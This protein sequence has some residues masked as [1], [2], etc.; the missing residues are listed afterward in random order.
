MPFISE[1]STLLPM[2]PP[3]AATTPINASSITCDF[4]FSDSDHVAWFAFPLRIHLSSVSFH[5]SIGQWVASLNIISFKHPVTE[6][7]YSS[8]RNNFPMPQIFSKWKVKSN[9]WQKWSQLSAASNMFFV[10]LALLLQS[11]QTPA[12]AIATNFTPIILCK[13][14]HLF[15]TIVIQHCICS[16]HKNYGSNATRENSV[17]SENC[18]AYSICCPIA[19]WRCIVPTY[20][21]SCYLVVGVYYTQCRPPPQTQHSIISI[22]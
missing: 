16:E 3:V 17:Y 15:F 6:K 8:I 11:V 12:E 5:S 1:I 18:T 9:Q 21:T 10:L 22:S 13:I 20:L 7:N 2:Q 4:L 14:L 19:Y